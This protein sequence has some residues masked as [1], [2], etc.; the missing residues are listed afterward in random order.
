MTTIETIALTI[1]AIL[2]FPSLCRW[3]N[4]PALLYSAF[5]LLGVLLGDFLKLDT[6]F[7]LGEVGKV[8]FVLLLFMVGL[9][10]DLP[11]MGTLRKSFPFCLSWLF[12]QIPLFVLLSMYLGYGP[13][14]GLVAGAGINTCS[15]GISYSLLQSQRGIIDETSMRKLLL[16]MVVLEIFALFILALSDIFFV[17]GWSIKILF[18]SAGLVGF[19]LLIRLFSGKIYRQLSRLIEIEGKWKLHQTLLVLFTIAIIGDR[20][21]LSAAKTA[22]FLGLFMSSTTHSGV[23]FEDELRPIAQNVLIPIFFIGLGS[24]ISIPNLF[25]LLLPLGIFISALLFAIRYWIFRWQGRLEIP[26][27]YFLLLCPNLTMVAVAAGILNEHHVAQPIIDGLLA[28][29]LL[30]TIGSAFWFPSGSRIRVESSQMEL[31]KPI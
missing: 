28:A 11:P 27:R 2:I 14:V 31:Q 19:I 1:A 26:R 15:L 16:A 6:R 23:K 7:M 20:L 22:F 25:P 18:H 10:I 30:M 29:G 9:E 17:H 21:G 4:R 5:L 12:I 8:G 3:I 24:R 13:I